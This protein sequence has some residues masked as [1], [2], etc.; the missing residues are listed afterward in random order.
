LKEFD[1]EIVFELFAS[2]VGGPSFS[3]VDGM[4]LR[5]DGHPRVRAI[6]LI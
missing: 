5:F 3:C 2:Q 1:G 6:T 4:D